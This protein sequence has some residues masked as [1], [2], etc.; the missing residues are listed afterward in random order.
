MGSKFHAFCPVIGARLVLA[1]VLISWA[2]SVSCSVSYDRKAI[3]ID[4]QRRILIS[5]SIHYPRSTPEM[6]PD[7]IQKAKAG[8]LDVIQTYVFWNGHEPSR[9]KYYFEDRF[10]LVRFIK[11]VQHAGL[12]V[13]LR[14]GPYVCA[15]WNF[16]GFPVWLKYVP[17]IA[18]R[19][20]NQPF[21]DAMQGFTQKIVDMMKAEKLFQPQGGPIILSQIENEFE[22]VE[23][24]IGEPGK[25]YTK[26]AADMAVGLGTGVPWVMCKQAD[27]PDPVINTCNGFYCENFEPNSNDKPKMW[28]EVWTGWFTGFGG[29]VLHRPAE[30]LAFAV[31]RFIQNRGS[32]FNYYMYH[33]GTNFGRTTGGPFIATSY[34]FDAPIDEFGSLREPKWSHLRGLHLAIKQS[35]SALVAADPAVSSLGSKQE[36]HVFESGSGACAAFLANYDTQDSV[37]VTFRNGQYELPPWS[38]S[39]LPD[40]Q[41]AVYNTATV[42]Y[43]SSPIQMVPIKSAFPWQ[44]YREETFCFGEY[45]TINEGLPEQISVTRDVS[46]YL[47]YAINFTISQDEAFLTNGQY[48]VLNVSS[49][50]HALHVF[51]NGQQAG[52]VYGGQENPKLTYSDKVKL[53]AGINKVSVLSVAVGL[54]NIGLHYETWNAG[55]LGPI[56]LEGMNSG[57]WDLTKW[58][59]SCKVGLK[60]EDLSLHTSSGSSSVEWDGGSTLAQNQPLIWYKTTFHAPAGNTPLALDMNGMGKGQ[61][62]INGRSIGRHWPAYTAHGTCGTC[63][64]AGTFDSSKCLSNCGEASQRWYHIPRSWLNPTGNLLVVFEEWGG[65]PTQVSL[66]QRMGGSQGAG[67]LHGPHM[68]FLVFMLLIAGIKQLPLFR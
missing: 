5:G 30:D 31:T 52:S 15:E 59:W 63:N 7:L 58:K 56:T 14:I 1:L 12:Y 3:V 4:G 54:P 60:G 28:T 16:G 37:K 62:W 20:D 47:W 33:G 61:I 48:P 65:D 13:H 36:A 22:L 46:D 23:W 40:C 44:S 68:A 19:T 50:G 25:A 38:I 34:D 29:A 39:I 18:F 17:G 53:T 27:A 49:A 45:G 41:T 21:K 6:W 24:E 43:K 11:L 35:E 32:F 51:V 9:G 55:V 2:R 8:G 67:A 10:D 57:K 66:V 64:Y 26:W 42:G